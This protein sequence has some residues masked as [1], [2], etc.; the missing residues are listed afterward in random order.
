MAHW[1]QLVSFLNDKEE[2]DAL[3]AQMRLDF[4]R[5]NAVMGV[6]RWFI[7]YAEGTLFPILTHS[8]C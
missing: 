5:L 2:T 8:K 7:K 4:A 3:A 6:F 1:T